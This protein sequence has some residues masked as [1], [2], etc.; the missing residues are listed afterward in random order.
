MAAAKKT[1]TK[2]ESKG[3]S[4]L[5]VNPA[6]RAFPCPRSEYKSLIKSQPHAVDEDGTVLVAGYRIA[7]AE[8]RKA[9]LDKKAAQKARREH[10]IR[11]RV[12]K[13][14]SAA[15][16]MVEAITKAK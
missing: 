1:E 5:L 3:E 7:S 11:Q 13:E 4:I 8:D 9:W 6:G 16:A 12:A 2:A 14:Q 10:D 15:M